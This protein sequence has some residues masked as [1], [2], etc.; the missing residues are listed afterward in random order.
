MSHAR[1]VNLWK[2]AYS[3]THLAAHVYHYHEQM[4][5]SLRERHDDLAPGTQSPSGGGRRKHHRHKSHSGAGGAGSGRR[6]NWKP[7]PGTGPIVDPTHTAVVF[8]FDCTLSIV[9]LFYTLR[10]EPGR[11]M[12]QNDPNDFYFQL[13]G[14]DERINALKQFIH[15]LSERG[16]TLVILSFGHE[17]EVRAA[18]HWIGLEQ[19]FRAV[20]GNESYKGPKRNM[21]LKFRRLGYGECFFFVD[22]DRANYPEKCGVPLTRFVYTNPTGKLGEDGD[23]DGSLMITFPAGK[24]K[25]GSGVPSKDMQTI[26]KYLDSQ[27]GMLRSTKTTHRRKHRHRKS[28]S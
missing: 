20:Y 28:K 12:L 16:F 4:D 3:L 11:Q 9:H 1:A 24:H 14:G 7:F 25:H 27:V 22:D 6:Y 17:A 5:P 10:S 23:V 19:Y 21:L 8:D 26:I 13:F 2:K 15:A 18:L